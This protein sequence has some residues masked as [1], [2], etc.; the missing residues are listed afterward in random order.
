MIRNSELAVLGVLERGDTIADVA[1][2]LDRGES[3][4]SRTVSDLEKKELVRTERDGRYKRV[5][6]SDARAVELYQDLVRQHSHVDFPELLGG[7]ALEVLY[8]FDRPSSVSELA[9]RSGNYRNTV[10]RVLKHLRE[11][12]IVGT[13]GGEYRF[14]ADFGRLHEFARALAHHRNRRR[15]EK[16]APNGT[17]LWE[18]ADEFLAQTETEVTTPN[19]L[20]TGP[21][22]FSDYGL[23]LLLTGHRHYFYSD[24]LEELSPAD[25]CCHTLLIDDDT[26]HRSYCLLLLRVADIDEGELRTRAEKYGLEETVD[27]LLQYLETKGDTE[28]E[29]LPEWSEFTDL[30]A[31]YEVN[32]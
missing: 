6:P 22:R 9:E 25:L 27:A 2:K 17:I 21:A 28:D 4:V 8:Y 19:F 10:N 13:D 3:H 18:S 12:G 32:V 23:Q 16:V 7:V 1:A 5:Y 30:A 20:E 11:R 29:T 31:E 24:S 15:L 26:R 14:N